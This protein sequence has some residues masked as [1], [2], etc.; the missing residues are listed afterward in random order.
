MD[1]SALAYR[2]QRGLQDQ[3]EQMAIL[4]QRVSGSLFRDFFM[5]AVAGVGYSF[6]TWQWH[7]DLD[8]AAGMLRLV[9]GLGTRAVERTGNDYPRLMSLDKPELDPAS[10]SDRGQYCQRSVDG[11]DLDAQCLATRTLEEVLPDLPAW[12]GSMLTERDYRT[13]QQLAESGQ[14]RQID[15]GTC[16]GIIT[17][18]TLIDDF[19]AIMQTLQ[20]EYGNPVDIEFTLN[21]TATGDYLINLLQ[22]RPLQTPA[23]PVIADGKNT[24]S[25][26]DTK[27]IASIQKR[28]IFF[29]LNRNTMG[30]QLNCKIDAVIFI[31]PYQYYSLPYRDKPTV[32]RTVG[33]LNALYHETQKT[34]L[35]LSPGRIGTT[36][37]ELG[38]PVSFAEIDH[39]RILCE[40]ACS[41]AGYQ[42]ELS[43]GSHFFQDLVESGIFYAAIPENDR[44]SAFQPLFLSAEPD[45]M[46]AHIPDSPL[47]AGLIRLYEPENLFF[48]SDVVKGSCLCARISQ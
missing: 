19:R 3:D 25:K 45:L 14:R 37:P 46:G 12:L 44:E 36:S 11:L 6:N 28:D 32:A 1:N 41:Q 22:C 35:L 33:T 38:L 23:M 39:I 29:S 17:Q 31:D 42:P 34:I 9:I 2:Q 24:G 15:I 21:W 5:P 4:V 13:E 26:I 16:G 7:P 48:F 27:T 43:F 18:K 20:K 30:P 40:V 8:P 10:G 47:P